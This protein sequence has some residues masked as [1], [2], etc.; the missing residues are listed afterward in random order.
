M[1]NELETNTRDGGSQ[2]NQGISNWES[3][4][5]STWTKTK[6][7]VH[8]QLNS[9]T[10]S[11][12]CLYTVQNWIQNVSPM[13]SAPFGIKTKNILDFQFIFGC[14]RLD[15]RRIE[16]LAKDK[17]RDFNSRFSYILHLFSFPLEC[18]FAS[19]QLPF[20]P[21]SSVRRFGTKN[22]MKIKTELFNPLG[23]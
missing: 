22:I 7:I 18:V 9:A 1:T 8:K 15:P 4:F 6:P 16:P 3:K 11:H 23:L 2:W 17:E 19:L 10:I 14:F 12:C 20:G 13:S 21:F 5:M